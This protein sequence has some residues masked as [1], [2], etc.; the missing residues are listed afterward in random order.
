MVRRSVLGFIVIYCCR[1]VCTAGI[2][3]FASS[4]VLLAAI[5]LV[6]LN[7]TLV[8]GYSSCESAT[9]GKVTCYPAVVTDRLLVLIAWKRALT[10][11]LATL[12][13]GRSTL[14]YICPLWMARLLR[15][16]ICLGISWLDWFKTDVRHQSVDTFG[17]KVYAIWSKQKIVGGIIGKT[18]VFVMADEWGFSGVTQFFCSSPCQ[19]SPDACGHTLPAGYYW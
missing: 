7:T 8:A 9:V 13:I 16:I 5:S 3:F 2:V 17:I 10:L 19:L 12:I 4:L 18:K 14:L 6:T 11:I 15:Y 1:Y